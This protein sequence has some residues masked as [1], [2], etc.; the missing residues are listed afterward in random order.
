M[1]SEPTEYEKTIQEILDEF[2]AQIEDGYTQPVNGW[3]TLKLEALAAIME[4]TDRLVVGE[5]EDV[6]PERQE[7][8]EMSRSFAIKNSRN[9]LRASQRKALK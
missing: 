8:G 6:E 1:T 3:T 2:Q 4:S 7:Y 5:D 9:Q